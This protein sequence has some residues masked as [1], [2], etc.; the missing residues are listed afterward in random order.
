MLTVSDCQFCGREHE[1]N[2]FACFA[3]GKQC[4]HC[5]KSNHFKSKCASLKAK[6]KHVRSLVKEFEDS[7]QGS[8]VSDEVQAHMY[9]VRNVAPVKLSD[10][11]T[12]TLKV[13]ERH[14][15]RFQLDSGADCN[16]LPIHVYMAATGD[17]QLLKVKSSSVRL[18]GY[19]QRDE[20][21]VGQ[22]TIKVWRERHVGNQLVTRSA[23]IKCELVDGRNFHSILGAKACERLNLIE[24][25]DSDAMNP[26]PGEATKTKHVFVHS[27]R[28][29]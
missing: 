20:K 16:V 10:D 18:L 3:W 19:G 5:K 15:I 27:T 4:T 14:Y 17:E 23:F 28:Y 8:E 25:K 7:D 12:V 1:R 2:K 26:L 11:Q 9:S 29:S 21:S 24:V 22:V 13:R 6:K